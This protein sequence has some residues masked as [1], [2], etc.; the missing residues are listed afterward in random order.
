MAKVAV[1]LVVG[2]LPDAARVEEDDVSLFDVVG[3]L[4]AVGLEQ[5]SE[6]LGVVLVHLAPEGADEV[7]AGHAARL[8]THFGTTGRSVASG[9][10]ELRRGGRRSPLRRRP[11]ARRRRGRSGTSTGGPRP[12]SRDRA[13]G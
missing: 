11:C 10:S 12:P 4:H 2:V 3:G 6:T 8:L 7:L 5:A 1:E 9:R 13:D